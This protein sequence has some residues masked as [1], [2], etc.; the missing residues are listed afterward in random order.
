[1]SSSAF[2]FQTSLGFKTTT[3]ITC[4]VVIAMP[5]DM[6]DHRLKNQSNFYCPNG[7]SQHFVGETEEQR[8]R[9][10]LEEKERSLAWEKERAASLDKQLRA[11]QT[12]ARNLKKRIGAGVCPCCQRTFKQLA[13]H[14]AHKHPDYKDEPK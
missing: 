9:R 10:R 2:A 11:A 8:L 4:G 12:K 5:T 7:H 13:A 3:C 6:Y 14:M 1:M